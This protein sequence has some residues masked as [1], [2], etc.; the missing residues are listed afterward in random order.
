QASLPSVHP[1][2]SAA[3]FLVDLKSKTEQDLVK[4]SVWSGADQ[5]R[6]AE[7]AGMLKDPNTEAQRLERLTKAL[8]TYSTSFSVASVALSDAKVDEIRQLRESAR[9]LRAE[10]DSSAG[11]AFEKEN[12]KGVGGDTWRAM[13]DAARQYSEQHAYPGEAFPV[14]SVE[15]NCVL[16]QQT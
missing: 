14:T 4:A 1:H 7:L 10:A 12:L 15:S 9:T 6:L 8:K 11:A 3:A 13:F 16:C 5:T 2:A